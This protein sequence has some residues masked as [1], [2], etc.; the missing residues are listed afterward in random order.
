M[1]PS[2]GASAAMTEPIAA[3]S[4]APHPSGALGQR[5][6][7]SRIGR[8]AFGVTVRRERAAGQGETDGV[9]GGDGAAAG[10]LEHRADVGI[11]LGSP[12]GAEGVRD[13]SGGDAG[14]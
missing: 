5:S 2:R 8:R 11:E 7:K 3:S 12:F 4:Q 13:F 10:G 14:G 1:A 9:E 6:D